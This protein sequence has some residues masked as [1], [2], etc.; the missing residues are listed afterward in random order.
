MTEILTALIVTFPSMIMS[1]IALYKL[2]D[3]DKNNEKGHGEVRDRLHSLEA[4]DANLAATITELKVDLLRHV[5]WEESEKWDEL[6]GSIR[7]LHDQKE[8]NE[9]DN[10]TST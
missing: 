1:A 6:L 9:S 8:N 7:V 4:A 3:V 10:G 2:F 5:Q